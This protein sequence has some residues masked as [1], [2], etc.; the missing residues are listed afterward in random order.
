M[1]RKPA[2][3]EYDA[4][5]EYAARALAARAHSASELRRKLSRRAANR[6]DVQRVMTGLKEAGA[7]SDERFAESFAASRLSNRGFG[8]MRVVRE[9]RAR[10]VGQKIADEAVSSVYSD[11]D[12]IELIDRYIE[13]K[14]R[15]KDL[16]AYL[17]DPKNL[18]SAFRKLRMAGFSSGNSI[19]ALKKYSQSADELEDSDAPDA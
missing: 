12:E 19:S 18:Q 17:A 13:R 8:R 3:L 5:M 7:L 6:E 2:P 11:T 16:P 14:F 9:L 15:G 4:L 10:Q 1:I